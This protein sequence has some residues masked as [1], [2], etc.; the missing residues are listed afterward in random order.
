TAVTSATGID[1][2]RL[3]T[4]TSTTPTAIDVNPGASSSFAGEFGGFAV[5]N[6]TLYFH[7][8]SATYGGDVLFS[9]AAGSS[10]ATEVL[11]AGNALFNFFQFNAFHVASDGLFFTDTDFNGPF[12]GDALYKL[13]A[14]NGITAITFN[15]DALTG[16]GQFGGF[17]EFNNALYF[18]AAPASTGIT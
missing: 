13:D 8:F 4:A 9:L 15:G 14:G 17:V 18:A 11:D 7:A 5:F 10:T 6:D 1:L 3:D 12:S 16:A 2:F